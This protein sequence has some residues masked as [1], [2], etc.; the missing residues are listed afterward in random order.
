MNE[1]KCF[2]ANTLNITGTDYYSFKKA[3]TEFECATVI[4]TVDFSVESFEVLRF[5]GCEDGYIVF[6][7]VSEKGRRR[8]RIRADSLPE[9]LLSELQK[10]IVSYLLR[11]GKS[12]FFVKEDTVTQLARRLQLSGK[13]LKSMTDESAMAIWNK[14]AGSK[15]KYAFVL[16]TQHGFHV[17]VNLFLEHAKMNSAI[18]FTD[19]LAA[20]KELAVSFWRITQ[21]STKIIFTAKPCAEGIFPCICLTF[22]DS[23]K[24]AKEVTLGIKTKSSEWPV[25]LL[26][27]KEDVLIEEYLEKLDDISNLLKEAEKSQ[28]TCSMNR[29]LH[30][31][32]V[33]HALGSRR[34]EQMVADK[35]KDVPIPDF[36][37]KT[38]AIPEICGPIYKAADKELSYAL[39]QAIYEIINNV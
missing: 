36:I 7:A 17:L 24:T 3:R 29:I 15:R 1:E 23:G 20:E 32:K 22:S 2:I 16:R 39:G 31:E 4:V 35:D 8:I 6:Y 25:S 33:V 21:D 10:G 34:M 30:N 12:F 5:V 37:R 28:N 19:K 11:A 9:I 13:L 38:I 27:F 26:S 18:T 14:I